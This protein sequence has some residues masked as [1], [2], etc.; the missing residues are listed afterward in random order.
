MKESPHYKKMP[1]DVKDAA[2]RAAK[3]RWVGFIAG[4]PERKS[5][6]EFLLFLP[7]G[8]AQPYRR[9]DGR[10]VW[11]VLV[12]TGV[13][14]QYFSREAAEKAAKSNPDN[15]KR[16]EKLV[17]L[18]GRLD[19]L[20]VF[21]GLARTG[22]SQCMNRPSRPLQHFIVV[23]FHSGWRDIFVDASQARSLA[24]ADSRG[25]RKYYAKPLEF[26]QK[27]IDSAFLDLC[28]AAKREDDVA[29]LLKFKKV[30]FGAPGA[31][32]RFEPWFIGN[33]LEAGLAKRESFELVNELWKTAAEAKPEGGKAL[34]D[35]F[36]EIAFKQRLHVMLFK[37]VGLPIDDLPEVEEV[38]RKCFSFGTIK[39]S[40]I[41]LRESLVFAVNAVLVYGEAE[42]HVWTAFAAKHYN[43]SATHIR[44]MVEL[45]TKHEA[46]RTREAETEEKVGTYYSFL[47]SK[48][49]VVDEAAMVDEE[50]APGADAEAAPGADVE[51]DEALEALCTAWDALNLDKDKKNAVLSRFLMSVDVGTTPASTTPASDGADDASSV[52]LDDTD[53]VSVADDD[54][55]MWWDGS[56]DADDDDDDDHDHDNNDAMEM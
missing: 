46:A 33:K 6:K 51:E 25:G 37:E 32:P 3:G 49:P 39:P 2:K 45:Q 20:E 34:I 35:Y 11:P 36:N 26:L 31:S 4:Q 54:S 52:A 8:I 14:R 53:K 43:Y 9:A 15:V 47:S 17:N 19:D 29:A 28:D 42:S 13:Y 12:R 30:T 38:V 7:Y 40:H 1:R 16:M 50:D 18:A 27:I 24:D 5:L 23:D 10:E 48:A 55:P 56:D 44:F 22:W 41:V 21:L